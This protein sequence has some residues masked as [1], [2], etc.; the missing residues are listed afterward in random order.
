MILIGL[1]QC[2]TCKNIE[3]Q[4]KTKNI[5]YTYRNIVEQPPTASELMTWYDKAKL[6]S[7]KQLANTSG[8]LYRELQLKDKLAEGTLETQCQLLSQ[9]GMLVKRPIIVTDTGDIYIGKSATEFAG[10]IV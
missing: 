5:D 2:S 1:P 8:Q 3:K 9:N 4:F 10:G 7:I 6:T